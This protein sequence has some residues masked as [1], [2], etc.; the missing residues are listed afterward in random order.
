MPR[1][2]QPSSGI[3]RIFEYG[4]NT[5]DRHSITLQTGSEGGAI[6]HETWAGSAAG[7]T[8]RATT[9]SGLNDNEWHHC[10]ISVSDRTA[11]I[12]IDGFEDIPDITT[13]GST[14]TRASSR[15]IGFQRAGENG[16]EIHFSDFRVYTRILS[17]VEAFRI[18]DDGL[19]QPRTSEVV[20]NDY[21][22]RWHPEIINLDTLPD[23]AGN[24][25][26]TWVDVVAP[27]DENVTPEQASRDN[28]TLSRRESGPRTYCVGNSLTVDAITQALP[29]Q[30]D[31]LINENQTLD[32]HVANPDSST[33][34]RSLVYGVALNTRTYDRIIAQPFANINN[35]HPIQDDIDAIQTLLDLQPDADLVIYD[36][37]PLS[38][39]P[40]NLDAPFNGSFDYS[41]AYF[42][43]LMRIIKIQNPT[44]DVSRTRT[45]E[46]VV[47]A[48]QRILDG[49]SSLTQVNIGVNAL[50]ADGIHMNRS[51]GAWLVHNSIRRHLGIEEATPVEVVYRPGAGTFNPDHIAFARSVL[52]EIYLPEPIEIPSAQDVVDL[53]ER[54]GG[55]LDEAHSAQDVAELILANPDNPLVTDANGRVML[56]AAT[57]ASLFDD[58]DAE[59]QLTNFLNGL[60]ERF[61]DEGDVAPAIIVSA[62][63]QNAQ[64]MQ[65]ISD[66]AASR[67]AAEA[68]G[69]AISDIHSA[70]DV[71]AL[72]EREGGFASESF[73]ILD[74]VV[75][76]VANAILTNP[77]NP[78]T[79]DENGRVM[80][81][82]ATMASL[83]DDS[84]AQTQLQDFFAGLDARFDNEGDIAPTVIVATM[85]LNPQ[86]MQLIS[87]ATAAR[88]AAEANQTT[89]ATPDN[90][91]ADTA[92]ISDAISNVPQYGDTQIVDGRPFTVNRGA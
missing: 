5:N 6:V 17:P 25:D 88:A 73:N 7:G 77:D 34:T 54:E 65:L 15:A 32:F 61:D 43:E 12:C 79:T 90:F 2:Q 74:S 62:I 84:D 75:D 80:L 41:A 89:L 57:M 42:E 31:R 26:L 63:L 53:V 9:R 70:E 36:G 16:S 50:Y 33:N 78:L 4:I 19:D 91:K 30:V 47:R 24:H 39:G 64:I 85:L 13:A 21:E 45:L 56:T 92:P 44:R 8:T 23:L 14:T 72:V 60:T 10:A 37:F 81:T 68:N 18:Y 51:H 28:F 27:G 69:T 67:A 38:T 40:D 58:S 66:A 20:A 35:P 1:E 52:D 22:A 82:A 11:T 86:I 83:F 59:T 49:D 71:V 55:L 87:D 48:K 3:Q 46:T 76:E 29:G